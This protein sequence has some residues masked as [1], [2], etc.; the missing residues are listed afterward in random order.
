MVIYIVDPETGKAKLIHD[1]E[2]YALNVTLR[3]CRISYVKLKA[4]S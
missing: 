3:H 2:A 1:E 4:A